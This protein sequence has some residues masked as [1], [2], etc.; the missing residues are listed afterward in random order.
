MPTGTLMKKAQFHERYP[1]IIPPTGA[2]VATPRAEA[3]EVMPKAQ[4]VFPSG[5]KWEMMAKLTA[6]SMALPMPWINLEP[7]SISIL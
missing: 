6:S 2:P 4:P 1:V 5:R 3:V 7:M